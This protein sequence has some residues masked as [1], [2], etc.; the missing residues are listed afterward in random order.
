MI[1]RF[2]AWSIGGGF[3]ADLTPEERAAQRRALAAALSQQPAPE[4]EASCSRAV[5]DLIEKEA[6]HD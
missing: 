5:L 4:T 6:G 2:V 3:P 1:A